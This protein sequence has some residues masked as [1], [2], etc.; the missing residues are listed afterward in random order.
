MGPACQPHYLN[1]GVSPPPPSSTASCGYKRRAPPSG[2]SPFFSSSP[3]HQLRCPAPPTAAPRFTSE[4][5]RSTPFSSIEPTR[6]TTATSLHLPPTTSLR[7]RLHHRQDHRFP[8]PSSSA[9]VHRRP[10][11]YDVLQSVRQFHEH[12][13]TTLSIT[14]YLLSKPHCPHLCHR[15]PQHRPPPLVSAVLSNTLDQVPPHAVKLPGSILP[16]QSPSASRK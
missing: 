11:L 8:A 15:S 5:H 14:S 16:G 9:R 13:M 12:H 4:H 1:S 6:R 3:P 10:A 2:A 7:R